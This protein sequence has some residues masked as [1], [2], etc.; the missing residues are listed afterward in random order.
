MHTVDVGALE[1]FELEKA[2]ERECECEAVHT[3]TVCSVEVTHFAVWCESPT[4]VCFAS[5]ARSLFVMGAGV[6]CF[7]CKRLARDC[8]RILP[9]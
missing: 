7:C 4:K 3:M 2:W 1:V 8:W 9:I 5:A 6:N